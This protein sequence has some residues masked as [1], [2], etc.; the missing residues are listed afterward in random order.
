MSA[1]VYLFGYRGQL[2]LHPVPS[3]QMTDRVDNRQ[4]QVF[5]AVR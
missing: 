1:T 2:K 4:N 3:K 5:G